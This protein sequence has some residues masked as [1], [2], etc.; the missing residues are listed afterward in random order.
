MKRV[1]GWHNH[2]VQRIQRSIRALI[3][4]VLLQPADAFRYAFR[5][6]NPT[7]EWFENTDGL[8]IPEIAALAEMYREDS[9]VAA[10]E[11]I[12]IDKDER[13]EE[14]TEPELIFLAIASLEREI[15]NG[16]FAQLF[17]NSSRRFVPFLGAALTAIDASM[18]RVLFERAVTELKLDHSIPENDPLRYFENMAESVEAPGVIEALDRID[19]EYYALGEDLAGKLLSFTRENI[20][21]FRGA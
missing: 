15:N 18:I 5:K 12:L 19:A 8:S 2:R 11:A 6:M 3:Q 16:G 14:L 13:E 7:M 4:R 20:R 9:L 10:I 21:E 1:A 17:E